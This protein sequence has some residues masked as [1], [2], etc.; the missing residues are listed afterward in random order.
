MRIGVDL[1]N[2]IVCY[3]ELFYSAAVERDLIAPDHA[4]SKES[5]RDSLRRAGRETEWTE[6]QGEVYGTRMQDAVPF[7]GVADFFW[8]MRQQGVPVCII[9]HRTQYPFLGPRHDLHA[10]ARNWLS[11]NGF[12]GADGP[13][14]D[15]QDVFFE[16]TKLEKLQ[17]ISECGCTHFIDDLP[18][19]LAEPA[20]PEGVHRILFAP[21]G[22]SS[23]DDGV[24]TADSWAEVLE[25]VN[26]YLR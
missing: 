5:I 9:S 3:D 14:H 7:P 8:G 12:L 21:N 10:S 19:L 4:K 13:G 25:L 16:P 24:V 6:L 15:V 22:T 26:E 11:T 18:E 2:T 17:R 1:D 23:P 20:F